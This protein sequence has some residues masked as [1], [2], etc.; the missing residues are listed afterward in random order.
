MELDFSR[1]ILEKCPNIKFHENPSSGKQVV[2]CGRTDR[3]VT[4]LIVAS[5]NFGSAQKSRGTAIRIPDNLTENLKERELESCNVI[6]PTVSDVYG[7]C[8]G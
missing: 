2:P 6:T 4:K 8:G 5:R 3:H 1:Q 7:V